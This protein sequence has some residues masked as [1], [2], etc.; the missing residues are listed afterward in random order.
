MHNAP[1]VSYPVGRSRFQMLFSSAVALL[2][3][4]ASA[5]W[6]VQVQSPGWPQWLMCLGAGLTAVGAYW[7][8]R[9]AVT[10]QLGWDA[11]QWFWSESGRSVP[12]QM[13]VLADL[14]QALLLC[15]RGARG[16]GSLWVWVERDASPMRWQALRRAV[17]Q[18]P[19]AEKD[20][21]HA[22]SPSATR[23]S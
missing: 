7:Q 22:G 4:F 16:A 1:A 2:G 21:L 5:A 20:P 19:R 13:L 17:H 23:P 14:Q 12:V 18:R 15:L 3:L 6:Y 9:H 10:G 11:S 8:W